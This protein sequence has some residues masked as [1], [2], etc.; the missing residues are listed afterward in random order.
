MFVVGGDLIAD[1]WSS[2]DGV[3]WRQE[4]ED[5]AFGALYSPT[6]VSKDGFLLVYGGQ[7]WT[8]YD[9]CGSSD[10][11]EVRS[12]PVVWASADG[13][14]WRLWTEDAPWEPRG[15]VHG[16]AVYGGRV[17]LIGGGF[18]TELSELGRVETS[19]ELSDI[20]SSSDG[21]DWRLEIEKFSFPAR[22]HFSTIGTPYGCFVSDGSVGTQL[23]TSNDLFFAKDCVHYESIPDALPH[24]KRHAS[25]LT[26]FNGSL[27]ILGGP[28]YGEGKNAGTTVWQYFPSFD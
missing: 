13:R 7:Y 3:S 26:Y 23:N 8:P 24:D 20:W 1:V 10:I 12:D 19:K 2:S 11:C 9:W 22:T 28:N 6:V 27:I 16:G 4:S 5:A 18:K 14:S 17:Y 25:S 15:L 21:K